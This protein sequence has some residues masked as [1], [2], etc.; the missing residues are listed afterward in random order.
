M[1]AGMKP[2]PLAGFAWLLVFQTAGEMLSRG[3]GLSLPGPVIG[4]VLLFLALAHP[5]VRAPVAL[6]AEFLLSHLALLFVPVAVGVMSY[7]PLLRQYG[8]K[9]LLV[10][11]VSTWI[12][13]TVTALVLRW[14][15]VQD[16]AEVR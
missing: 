9:L 10:L 15:P 16:D 11:V 14:L 3:L 1:I 4:M 12:G 6:C 7:L 13:I 2:S 5:A 8:V